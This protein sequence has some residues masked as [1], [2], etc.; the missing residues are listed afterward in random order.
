MSDK[1]EYGSRFLYAED[2]IVD[3][4]FR[5]VTLEISAWHDRGT[6]T[7]ANG[8][9]VDKPCVEFAG[10]SKMLALCKTNIAIGVICT[11]QQ[12]GAKWIGHKVTL[13]PR[14]V[15]AFGEKVLAL[16]IIPQSGTVLRKSLKDRL[17]AKAELS[18]PQPEKVTNEQG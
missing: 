8:K 4:A 14:V 2:L 18:V 12:P 6:I 7:A 1:H 3:G 16:R 5:T 10:K 13:Q 9:K 17:G 15:D 11:G